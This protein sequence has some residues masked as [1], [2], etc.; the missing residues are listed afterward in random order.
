MT[1]SPRRSGVAAGGGKGGGLVGAAEE[2][3]VNEQRRELIEGDPL[4]PSLGKRVALLVGGDQPPRQAA[5]KLQHRQVDLPVAAVGG[6]IDQPGV[7]GPVPE[8]VAPPQVAVEAGRRLGVADKLLKPS[9]EAQDGICRPAADRPP[10]GADLNQRLEPAGCVELR[11]ALAG[12]IGQGKGAEGG[13][14]LRPSLWVAKVGCAACVQLG[15]A[16]AEEDQPPLAATA[17]LD[18]LQGEVA[19]AHL[20]DGGDGQ[21]LRACKPAQVAGLLGKGA[22]RGSGAGLEEGD[23]PIGQPYLVGGVDVAAANRSKDGRPRRQFTGCGF[24]QPR[25]GPPQAAPRSRLPGCRAPARSRRRDRSRGR[26]PQVPRAAAEPSPAPARRGQ[27][28]GG[29]G[30]PSGPSPPASRTG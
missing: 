4:P 5:E 16:A 27:A 20:Q 22:G 23:P 17:L 12:R 19:A 24:G 25:Q 11:P 6:G 13:A 2:D 29:S 7:S 28:A 14:P 9:A 26:G 21:R 30:A 8:D 15:K 3:R 1:G 10:P 18:P